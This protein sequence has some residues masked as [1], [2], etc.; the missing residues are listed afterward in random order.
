MSDKKKEHLSLVTAGHIDAGKSSTCGRLIYELKGIPEREMEKL[1]N[2]A[3]ILGKQTFEFAFYMDT[4]KQER[5]RGIT[6][7]STTKEFYTDNYHYSLVDNPGHRSY[8]TNAVSGAS[9][10]D[11]ALLLVPASSEFVSA[12]AKGNHAE[13]EVAGQSRVH[14]RLLNL[15]GVKQ[16][17]VG[18][19]KMDVCE[20]KEDRYNEVKD[21]VVN[22]LV[23]VGWNKD[24]VKTSVPFIPYS[25]W[26]GDNVIQKSPNMPWYKGCEVKTIDGTMVTVSTLLDALNEYVKIPKR[27]VQ[28]PFRMPVSQVLSVKGVGSV[29]CGRIEQGTIHPGD[30]ILCLPQHNESNPC[31]GKIFSIEMHHKS[32]PS[33]EAGDNVGLCIKGLNK[34]YMPSHGSIMIM[35]SDS[36]K[37]AKRF[38]T[39]A[40]VLEHPGELKVGFCPLG[41]VRTAKAPIKMVEIKWKMGKETGGKKVESPISIK[42]GDVAEIVWEPVIPLVVEPFDKCEGLGRLAIMDSSVCVMVARIT[43]IE[44]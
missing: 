27:L 15:L 25:A 8:L 4:T 36:L 6:I 29:I 12:I 39:Q 42:A 14:A 1:K 38:T 10:G 35:K 18:I 2:E 7:Q 9:T 28:A 13:G 24:F 26:K 30:E 33:A 32:Q 34:D 3:A 23:Q 20:Y 5:E 21:E 16:L 31:S 41:L 37:L 44:Y 43:A 11:V 19:N 22:M 17:I 40:Q